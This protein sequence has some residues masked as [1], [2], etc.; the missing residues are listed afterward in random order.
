VTAHKLLDAGEVVPSRSTLAS[1]F[2]CRCTDCRH[3]L[4]QAG[5][6]EPTAA[7]FAIAWPGRVHATTCASYTSKPTAPISL[8]AQGLTAGVAATRL[9]ADPENA[10]GARLGASTMAS[11][12][13]L[14]EPADEELADTLVLCDLASD[15]L[16]MCLECTRLAAAVSPSWRCGHHRVTREASET[17][18]NRGTAPQQCKEF[19][20][21]RGASGDCAGD[22]GQ[23]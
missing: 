13:G 19:T 17:A 12:R 8:R 7:G 11:P 6:A 15:H 21:T 16:G 9:P 14:D 22:G 18:A 4:R 3:L 10:P 1:D 20:E 23:A 5:C 2:A